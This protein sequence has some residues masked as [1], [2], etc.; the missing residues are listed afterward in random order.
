MKK[1]FLWVFVS[2]FLVVQSFACSCLAPWE[3]LSEL[4]KSDLVFIWK[5]KTVETNVEWNNSVNFDISSVLKWDKN[6]EIQI[7]TPMDSAACWF[8]FEENKEYI[9]Y[10]NV[11]DW[12]NYVYLCSRTASTENAWDDLTAL[13][14]QIN[15]GKLIIGNSWT[16]NDD[17]TLTDQDSLDNS[18]EKSVIIWILVIILW[19]IL[20][21]IVSYKK[22][23]EE[24]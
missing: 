15:Q 18:I 11:N 5:V 21:W 17:E 16:N 6:P 7:S 10:S 24:K 20:F 1:I 9:V 22:S 23:K 2:F 8:N 13:S 19:I 14:N 12:K 4:E 3:P